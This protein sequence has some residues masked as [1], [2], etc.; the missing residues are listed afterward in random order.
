MARKKEQK[1]TSYIFRIIL[2]VVLVIS[3]ISLCNLQKKLIDSRRELAQL[4]QISNEKQIKV[5]ELLTLLDNGTEA[6]YIEKAAREK[7][8]YVYSDEQIFVDLSGN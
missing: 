5:N 7:L 6:D 2:A 4:Q 3:L 1:T 8:G